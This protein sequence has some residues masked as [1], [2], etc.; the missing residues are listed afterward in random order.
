MSQFSILSSDEYGSKLILQ[1]ILNAKYYYLED[2]DK[3]L[4]P[5]LASYTCYTHIENKEQHQII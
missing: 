4:F 5:S 1:H 3:T 2:A